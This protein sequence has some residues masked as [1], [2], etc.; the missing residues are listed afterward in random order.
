MSL[1]DFSR[2]QF[3][4]VTAG[5]A[6]ASL[7]G[8]APRS[9]QRATAPARRPNVLLIL[10]DDLGYADVG[11]H[12]CRD[13]P[14]PNLDRLAG[15]S[16]RFSNGY[17]TCPVCS[18]TRAGLLTGRYQQRYGHEFNPGPNSMSE[19][20]PIGLPVSEVTL[21]EL[22]AREGYRTGLVGKW[23]L[24]ETAEYHPMSRGFHDYFGF[25]GGAHAYLDLSRPNL[26]PIYRGREAVEEKEYL[27]DA[28]SREA[29]DFITRHRAEPFF[30]YL[31]YNAVHTPLAPPPRFTD[32]F[33]DI[34]NLRRRRMAGMLAAMDEG[35]GRVLSTLSDCGLAEDTLVFFL[36]DN[37]GPTGANGSNNLPLR[38]VKGT[39]W[40]G[41]IRVPF[42]LRWPSQLR[43]GRVYDQSVIAM[44]VF[45]TALA[46]VGAKAPSDRRMDG[47]DLLPF[48][49]G[50][51]SGRL[52]PHDFLYWRFGEQRAI[53]SGNL[54]W[55]VA[56]DGQGLFDLAE[57]VG[58]SRDLS[59]Q[60]PADLKQMQEAYA[61]WEVQL[62]EPLW[63]P[64]GGAVPAR[65][66]RRS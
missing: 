53:R 59:V 37:G 23:H 8:C 45:A 16:V 17:V 14:T 6:A 4:S 61:A 44:D 30:L 1:A 28:F 39:T 65:R 31:A 63:G 55:T 54:K 64:Q 56:R 19:G 12:G 2:R 46:A 29:S 20:R 42:L 62:A 41:G 7:L 51:L 33:R 15:E 32:S 52:G 26:R 22:L 60:K 47:E 5:A 57:D 13:I 3:L 40:E 18:P 43:G 34:Q 24:G 21:P 9:A 10:A 50:Q 58:E 38:G 36:S 48:L 35:I 25:L 66:A 49:T 11:F 27:T